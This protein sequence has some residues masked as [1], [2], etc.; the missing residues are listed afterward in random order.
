M[1]K[2]LVYTVFV[3]LCALAML[4]FIWTLTGGYDVT[5]AILQAQRAESE[6]RSNEALA[7][8]LW[9]KTALVQAEA[10]AY[11]TR[12]L[13]RVAAQAVSRQG[14][15]LIAQQ[16]IFVLLVISALVVNG[17]LWWSTRK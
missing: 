9:A 4:F 12:E 8:V 10:N 3:I 6:A 15:M 2:K 17:L 7:H 16:F 5:L 1:Y 11:V 14:F 13:G